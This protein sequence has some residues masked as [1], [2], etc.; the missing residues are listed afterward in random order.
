MQQT[1]TQEGQGAQPGQAAGADRASKELASL[2]ARREALQSQLQSLT[3]RRTMMSVQASTAE[4]PARA[5]IQGRLSAM[6]ARIARIDDELNSIDD[7][8]NASLA[9]GAERPN[10]FGELWKGTLLPPQA[11]GFP[12][13]ERRDPDNSIGVLAATQLLG[14]VLMS[15]VLW[16]WLRKRGPAVTGRLAPEDAARLEQLQRSVDVMAVE[17]ERISEAQRYVAKSIGGGAAEPIPV[18]NREGEV[19]ARSTEDRR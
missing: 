11:P 19:V 12:G 3:E 6:D 7:A 2:D 4:G 8:I 1:G 17:I 9:R 5:G 16:R 10:A 18:R 15:F 14:F 13:A